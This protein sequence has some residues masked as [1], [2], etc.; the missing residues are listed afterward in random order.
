MGEV[1]EI[2]ILV[3]LFHGAAAVE[4]WL[5]TWHGPYWD[6][7]LFYSL[8]VAIVALLATRLLFRVISLVLQ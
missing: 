3:V 4:S 6:L 2:I 7:F 1:G 8:G 5:D